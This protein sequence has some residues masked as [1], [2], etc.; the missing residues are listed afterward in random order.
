L[1]EVRCGWF[2][3]AHSIGVCIGPSDDQHLTLI[4]LSRESAGGLRIE[5]NQTVAHVPQRCY[6]MGN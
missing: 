3:Q 6:G 2:Q 4:F 1:L 5:G